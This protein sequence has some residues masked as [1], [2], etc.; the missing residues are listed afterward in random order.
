MARAAAYICV[1]NACSLPIFEPGEV[2]AS[3]DRLLEIR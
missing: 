3:A 1:N 2:I